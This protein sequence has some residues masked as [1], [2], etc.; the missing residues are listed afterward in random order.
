MC[1]QVPSHPP[2]QSQPCCSGSR[3]R[4]RRL[5]CHSFSEGEERCQCQGPRVFHDPCP[6]HIVAFLG[7]GRFSKGNT[8]VMTTGPCESRLFSWDQG[9]ESKIRFARSDSI[10]DGRLRLHWVS[11]RRP[12]DHA[13]RPISTRNPK[14]MNSCSLGRYLYHRVRFRPHVNTDGMEASVLQAQ[15]NPSPTSIQ[16]GCLMK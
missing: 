14:L 8:R 15:C 16:Q 1:C 7:R 11:A 12:D 6:R 9:F 10:R 13:P 5:F 3:C 4:V 2:R